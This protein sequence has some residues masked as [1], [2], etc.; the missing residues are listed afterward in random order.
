LVEWNIVYAKAPNKVVDIG[1]MLLV[2]LSC[3]QGFENLSTIMDLNN[4]PHFRQGRN[5]LAHNW[6]FM[7]AVIDLLD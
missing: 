4:L 3:Q 7:R 1:N 5:A 6:C 2:W